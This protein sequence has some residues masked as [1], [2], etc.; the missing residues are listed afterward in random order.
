MTK[1]PDKLTPS[2]AAEYLAARG[3]TLRRQSIQ[4]LCEATEAHPVPVLESELVEVTILQRQITRES[5]D[6]LLKEGLPDRRGRPRKAP[7]PDRQN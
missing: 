1:P 3:L 6:R 5:L 2:Q 4:Q 7:A